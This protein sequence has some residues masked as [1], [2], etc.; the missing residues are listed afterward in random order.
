MKTND[1]GGGNEW[2]AIAGCARV[3]E[4]KATLVSSQRARQP[5]FLQGQTGSENESHAIVTDGRRDLCSPDYLFPF[6]A[7]RRLR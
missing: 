3:E 6:V 7:E 4:S 1:V 5:P 2:R